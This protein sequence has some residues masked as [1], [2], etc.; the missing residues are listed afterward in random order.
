MLSLLFNNGSTRS[1]IQFTLGFEVSFLAVIPTVEYSW[2][3]NEFWASYSSSPCLQ[4]QSLGGICRW[5][6]VNLKPKFGLHW[7]FQASQGYTR[8]EWI[9][10]VYKILDSYRYCSLSRSLKKTKSSWCKLCETNEVHQ[11][12]RVRMRALTAG[13]SCW[14]PE[15]VLHFLF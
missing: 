1:V 15:R 8:K 2:G 11:V 10:L 5:I 13:P 12:I 9:L 6:S 7:E 14:P 4:F 3:K